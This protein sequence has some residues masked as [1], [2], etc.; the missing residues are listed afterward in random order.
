[1][2]NQNKFLILWWGVKSNLRDY[3]AQSKKRFLFK[4]EC[5]LDGALTTLTCINKTWN[6]GD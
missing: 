4:T 6:T 5:V 3:Y 2:Q 1:M